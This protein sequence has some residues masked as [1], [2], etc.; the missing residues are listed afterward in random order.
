MAA[1]TAIQDADPA[2]DSQQSSV[3]RTDLDGSGRTI[4]LK[5]PIFQ[6]GD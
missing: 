4:G 6:S 5:T 1:G 2:K 3:A